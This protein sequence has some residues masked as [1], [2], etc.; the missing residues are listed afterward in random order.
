MNKLSQ[1]HVPG[2]FAAV[3]IVVNGI[4]L[5]WLIWQASRGGL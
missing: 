4:F 1:Q 2:T 3:V 5:A